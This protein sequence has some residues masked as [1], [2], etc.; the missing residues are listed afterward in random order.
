[1]SYAKTNSPSVI[2]TTD[3]PPEITTTDSPSEITTTDSTP[4]I[5][6]IS[7]LLN[8]AEMDSVL[9]DKAKFEKFSQI[10]DSIQKNIIENF[11]KLMQLFKEYIDAVN[12]HSTHSEEDAEKHGGG[13]KGK[14]KSKKGI[15][16]TIHLESTGKQR[17]L[18]ERGIERHEVALSQQKKQDHDTE[19]KKNLLHSQQ[20][21]YLNGIT[22]E[23]PSY[24]PEPPKLCFPIKKTMGTEIPLGF[25]L[26]IAFMLAAFIRS[27]MRSF[28]NKRGGKKSKKRRTRNR[29]QKNRY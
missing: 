14:S 25:T 16:S 9:E 7:S 18:F 8:N 22:S 6:I 29:T 4:G 26:I 1:M 21:D 5:Q 10:V 19:A 13:R 3:S 12:Y 23:A 2:T 11:P 28:N 24:Q 15:F 27:K 20:L 17:Q